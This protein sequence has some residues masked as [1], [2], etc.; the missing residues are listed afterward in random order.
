VVSPM[1]DCMADRSLSYG[2]FKPLAQS[3]ADNVLI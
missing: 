1:S 2:K 3:M